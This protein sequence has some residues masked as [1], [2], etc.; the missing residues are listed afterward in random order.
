MAIRSRRL[1]H[2]CLLGSCFLPSL[3]TIFRRFVL[4][5][6]GC[7]TNFQPL[8]L[9]TYF[10]CF[11]GK[12]CTME[13][14]GQLE[15]KTSEISSKIHRLLTAKL[16]RVATSLRKA[17]CRNDGPSSNGKELCGA[18][19]F[20]AFCI[21]AHLIFNALSLDVCRRQHKWDLLFECRV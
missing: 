12:F 15:H 1:W 18:S 7:S 21:S 14:E 20:S 17:R 5:V 2:V 13:Q 8:H 16:L 6:F 3:V 10:S 19:I 11:P 4:E 9:C